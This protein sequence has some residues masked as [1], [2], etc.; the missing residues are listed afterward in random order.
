MYRPEIPESFKASW[1]L[2][3]KIDRPQPTVEIV[4]TLW[5]PKISM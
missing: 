5:I 2:L 3:F 1:K 4:A